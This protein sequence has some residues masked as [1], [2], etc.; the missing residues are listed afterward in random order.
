MCLDGV[1]DG[2]EKIHATCSAYYRHRHLTEEIEGIRKLHV[3]QGFPIPSFPAKDV[4]QKSFSSCCHYCYYYIGRYL[5][6]Q[7]YM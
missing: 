5:H 6:I 2:E 4:S 1:I 3:S 7:S